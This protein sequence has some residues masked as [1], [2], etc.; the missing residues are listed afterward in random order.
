MRHKSN[1]NNSSKNCHKSNSDNS[2]KN[3]HKSNSNNTSK[4]NNHDLDIRLEILKRLWQSRDFEISHLWQR[5]VFL[6]AY[7]I[8]T[9]TA[10]GSFQLKLFQ[11]ENNSF[12]YLCDNITNWISIAICFVGLVV[13][14]LW[15]MMAKGSK[16]VY[17][18]YEKAVRKYENNHFKKFLPDY[19][20]PDCQNKNPLD[21]TQVNLGEHKLTKCDT[22]LGGERYSL[23]KINIMVGIVSS[24]I[25]TLLIV[26]HMCF[27]Y[28]ELRY[29]SWWTL[30]FIAISFICFIALLVLLQGKDSND[31]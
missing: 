22:L 23:S 14:S 16:N 19:L 8:L 20:T 25:F 11:T 17:E 26:V 3:C 29:I 10:Y 6:G 24:V 1:S 2:S 5:S 12:L 4:N 15:I 7:L 18:C 27:L 9:Y 21:G 30:A 31:K 28:L 13:S